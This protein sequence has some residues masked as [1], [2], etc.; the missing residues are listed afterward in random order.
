MNNDIP[1][2]DL[3]PYKPSIGYPKYQTRF[4]IRLQGLNGEFMDV[5]CVIKDMSLTLN[6]EIEPFD[7]P[8]N[9]DTTRTLSFSMSG[10]WLKMT[11]KERENGPSKLS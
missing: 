8:L 6:E 2:I 9:R 5:D 1:V 7:D 10:D 3:T 11:T 4:I